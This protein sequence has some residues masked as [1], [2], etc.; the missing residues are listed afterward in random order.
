MK[1]ESR[2]P[3]SETFIEG[4]TYDTM[5][6]FT[7]YA[8]RVK[9]IRKK[10]NGMYY[11]QLFKKQFVKDDKERTTWQK[12]SGWYP[13]GTS[14]EGVISKFELQL[15]TAQQGIV[16]MEDENSSVR[17]DKELQR[18]VPYDPRESKKPF[19]KKQDRVIS[20]RP[21]E[22]AREDEEVPFSAD[23]DLPF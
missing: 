13:I 1:R 6:A 8:T 23:S 21:K 10:D 4:E 20:N 15:P 2:A 9:I 11:V 18:Y 5:I 7:M 14:A 19:Q 17:Y 3:F 22:E 16:T 12:A